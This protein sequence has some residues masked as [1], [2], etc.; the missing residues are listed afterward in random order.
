MKHSLIA[1]LVIFNIIKVFGLPNQIENIDID[2][3]FPDEELE[4]IEVNKI[5]VKNHPNATTK[6]TSNESRNLKVDNIHHANGSFTQHKV[7]N[8]TDENVSFL[9]IYI[10]YYFYWFKDFYVPYQSAVRYSFM[11]DMQEKSNTF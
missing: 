5:K 8:E 7:V 2:E 1:L 6:D 3:D 9:Y 10:N 4:S 11:I